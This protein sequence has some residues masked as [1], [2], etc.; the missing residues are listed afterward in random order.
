MDI[1]LTPFIRLRTEKQDIYIKYYISL[2]ENF[3]YIVFTVKGMRNEDGLH[4][5]RYAEQPHSLKRIIYSI[6]ISHP[7]I[8]KH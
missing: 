8:V 2:D 7:F 1:D 6:F 4:F 5:M 3:G